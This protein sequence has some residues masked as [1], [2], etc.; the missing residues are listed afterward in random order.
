MV[1]EAIAAGDIQAIN[2]F[3]AQKYTEALRDIAA[4]PNS[5]TVMVPLEA[6]SLIGSVAGIAELARAGEREGRAMTVSPWWWVALAILLGAVE[7][8]TPTTVLVWSALARRS[9]PPLV[10]WLAP[11]GLAAQVARL[12]GRSRSSS[13]S[14][15]G[16]CS[17]A[18]GRRTT[19]R[20][21]TAA[22]TRCS[23]ARRW[24]SPSTTATAR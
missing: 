5:K 21:S 7:M 20:R 4:S 22:P 13:P 16:R 12:R 6:A 14:P 3:V 24:S 9:S 18:G 19:A 17:S 8:L 10:L 15:A 2:Y 23:A 11:L 1:S